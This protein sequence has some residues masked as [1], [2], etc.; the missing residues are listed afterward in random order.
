[1]ELKDRIKAAR[2]HAS[3][4][5]AVLLNKVKKMGQATLSDLENGKTLSSKYLIDIARA[6]NV[7]PIWL[8]TGEGE[9]LTSEQDHVIV[10]GNIEPWDDSTLLGS[11]EIEIPLIK[12][13][14]L[15]A[16]NGSIPVS[17]YKTNAKLRFSKSTLKKQGVNVASS[18][19][20]AVSGNSMEPFI[21]DG[22]TV[23]IDTSKTNIIDGKVYAIAIDNDLVRLKLLY[24]LPNNRVRIRSYNRDEYSDE[25]YSLENIRVIGKMFW[26]S[27][28]C[29]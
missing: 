20:V 13:I 24:N 4:T 14:E 6:C 22:A 11:D 17:E 2:K 25:E 23:G 21:P 29:D 16:G 5:Q 18:I 8:Q 28:L 26:Y 15:S 10:S 19:C 9:M 27:V 3:F 1:M 12:E 7:S